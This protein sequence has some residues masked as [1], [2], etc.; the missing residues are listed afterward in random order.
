MLHCSGPHARQDVS[1]LISLAGLGCGGM[2]LAQA[3]A[4]PLY[5]ILDYK[6]GRSGQFTIQNKYPVAAVFCAIKVLSS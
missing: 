4:F 3:P 2:A 1:L 6:I 5:L